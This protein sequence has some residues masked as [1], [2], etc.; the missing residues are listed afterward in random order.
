MVINQIA[1]DELTL[2]AAP[3]LTHPRITLLI[4]TLNEAENLP[5]IIPRIPPIVD[6]IWLVDGHSTDDTVA[7]AKTLRR[8]IHVVYQ[9]GK[10]KGDAIRCGI[11]CATGDIIVTIDADGSMDPKEIPSFVEPLLDGYDFV[12]GSRFLDGAGTVDMPTHRVLGNK[13]FVLI[14]NLLFGGRFTDLCYG[15]NAFK[16]EAVKGFEIASDG[17]EIETELNIKA[18]KAGLRVK[19]VPSCEAARLNGKG[20]LKTFSDGWRIL[21]TILRERFFCNGCD[22]VVEYDSE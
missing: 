4:F 19:E 16:R 22:A 12:K 17:F 5:Y 21:K 20:N 7:I 6:E 2:A 18:L 3:V 11:K 13:A 8:D 15:Y 10:G 1:R 14:V 9:D